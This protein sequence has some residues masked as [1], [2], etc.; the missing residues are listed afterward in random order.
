MKQRIARD[1]ILSLD[2]VSLAYGDIS[3]LDRISIEI[4]SGEILGI[5]G[6]NGS[7]KSSLLRLMCGLLRPDRGRV[8]LER[9]P[10]PQ[11][12]PQEIAR[13]IGMVAQESYF[14]FAF[15]VFEVVLM[16]RFPHLG[17]LQFE[18]AEDERVAR[19]ALAA[20]QCLELADRSIN[21]L[22]GGER[23]RVLIARALAQEPKLLLFDEPTSFLDLRFKRDIFQLILRLSRE[24]NMAVV[25]VSHDLDL[26]AQYCS[27]VAMLKNGSIYRHG[28][29]EQVIDAACVASVFD[30]PVTVDRHPATG[31]PRVQIR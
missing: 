6:P 18:G 27:R 17:R 30:C 20:T 25:V 21:E 23:Q 8:L 10:L 16:G 28:P 19:Q 22:S 13:R 12:S 15:S 11:L 31:K 24:Q 7:G 1:S 26:A 2:A 9:R 29:P 3:V 14:Q 4:N 5:L